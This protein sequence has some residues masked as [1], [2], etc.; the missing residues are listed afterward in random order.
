[1][2]IQSSG[3]PSC[4]MR[5]SGREWEK[6]AESFLR[7]R[8][9]TILKRN[10]H[11][12]FGEIDLIM[13]HGNCLVFIEVRYRRRDRYG[14]GAETVSFTKQSKIVKTAAFFLRR[15]RRYAS[16]TCR[17]DVISVGDYRGR[18]EINWIRNAF[19]AGSYLGN[20]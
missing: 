17:F 12:R 4:N 1:M 14:N 10:Y 18:A 8:G 15:Y 11:C 7:R 13:K 16:Q 3:P 2:K 20:L 5:A 9:L 6:A 19:D